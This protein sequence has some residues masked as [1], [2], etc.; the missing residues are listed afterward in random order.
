MRFAA[1][2]DGEWGDYFWQTSVSYS[3][4]ERQSAGGDTMV[5]RDI[6]ARQGLGG[7]ECE[8]SVPNE[9]DA[10]GNLVF[11]LETLQAHAGQGPCQ[12]WIPFSNSMAGSNELV[13]R[14]EF[15][16]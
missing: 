12:Y 11:S 5:Y 9:Y 14:A 2:L 1:A 4:S 3:K 15:E 8:A 6:R 7:A 16:P 10:N 13:L